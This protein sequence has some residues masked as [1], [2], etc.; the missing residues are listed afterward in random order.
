MRI[1]YLIAFP[2]ASFIHYN[3]KYY[4]MPWCLCSLIYICTYIQIIIFQLTLIEPIIYSLFSILF[5]QK[6][7]C[8]NKIKNQIRIKYHSLTGWVGKD[9]GDWI[10]LFLIHD[11]H[12]YGNKRHPKKS[13]L[14]I[15]AIIIQKMYTNR[16]IHSIKRA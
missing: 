7:V 8:L 6:N 3:F 11:F 1:S 15:F 9:R 4:K 10:L 16:N 5:V 14:L 2:N 13:L 12:W